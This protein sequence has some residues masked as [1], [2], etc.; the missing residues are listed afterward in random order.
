MVS[1]PARCI[2]RPQSR[3]RWD[4]L[5]E[6]EGFIYAAQAELEAMDRE[7]T[8]A[9]RRGRKPDP[10]LRRRILGLIWMLTFAGM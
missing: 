5:A 3:D 4:A 10:D 1:D 6:I 7:R 2:P 9:R 8:G